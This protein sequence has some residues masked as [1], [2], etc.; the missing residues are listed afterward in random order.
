MFMCLSL[1]RLDTD[2]DIGKR[3]EKEILDDIYTQ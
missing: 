2:V 1:W 3:A